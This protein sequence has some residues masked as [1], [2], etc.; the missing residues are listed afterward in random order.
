MNV[1]ISLLMLALFLQLQAT[2]EWRAFWSFINM[3]KC[4]QLIR[5][6]GCC[7]VGGALALR[8]SIFAFNFFEFIFFAYPSP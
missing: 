5:T 2:P 6:Q 7:C 1:L 3:S 4:F 8:L